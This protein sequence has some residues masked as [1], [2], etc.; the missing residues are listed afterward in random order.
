LGSKGLKKKD[1]VEWF[2][3]LIELC[4]IKENT[5]N[6]EFAQQSIESIPL[7]EKLVR[8]FKQHPMAADTAK[9]IADF[10][11]QEPI[12][13]VRLVLDQLLFLG[14]IERVS[15]PGIA[16]PVFMLSSASEV[17]ELIGRVA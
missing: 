12:K 15:A 13:N 17:Q 5:M 3:L 1:G 10:W 4:Q 2:L 7:A 9:G 8:Y 14:V 6:K 11:L 16:T